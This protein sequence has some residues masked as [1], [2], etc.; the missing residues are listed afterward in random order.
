MKVVQTNSAQ[1]RLKKNAPGVKIHN[2][3]LRHYC[4]V[5]RIDLWGISQHQKVLRA[6]YNQTWE[7]DLQ[8]KNWTHIGP[9]LIKAPCL[10]ASPIWT[11][12]P[13]DSCTQHGQC[14][15]YSYSVC[16]RHVECATGMICSSNRQS[17]SQLVSPGI[18]SKQTTVFQLA[19]S[20]FCQVLV[21]E[22]LYMNSTTCTFPIFFWR[23]AGNR[24]MHWVA[25]IS[26][27]P[28]CRLQQADRASYIQ[29]RSCSD[30]RRERHSCS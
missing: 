18:S 11:P 9:L 12:A 15:V 23:C 6:V 3:Q 30:L 27:V 1:L 14:L 17:S 7:R 24:S 8:A 19:S 22:R 16:M 21:S 26:T 4:R 29:R 2:H 25:T 10:Q 13:N 5:D 28:Y 20:F